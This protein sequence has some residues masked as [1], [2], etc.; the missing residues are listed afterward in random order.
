MERPCL[1]PGG[2]PVTLTQRTN[3]PADGLIDIV[4]DL[5]QKTRFSI[6]LRIPSWS[7]N[8]TLQVNGAGMSC[9][10]GTYCEL[11]REWSPQDSIVLRLDM[12]PRL[13]AG[14]RN[15][16]GLSVAYYGPLLLAF[17]S[18]EP[19]ND[20]SRTPTLSITPPP[21]V[22]AKP[23]HSLRVA[24]KSSQGAATLRDFAGAGQSRPA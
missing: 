12:S 3:Y 13:E 1:T 5:A 17:D 16:Q 11:N 6:W 10:P 21:Q 2:T 8:T 22:S 18:A 20:L 15:A 9:I 19:G 7:R 14:A 4:V 23:D 24:F